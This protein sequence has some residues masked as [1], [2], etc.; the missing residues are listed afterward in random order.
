MKKEYFSNL[1][2]MLKSQL[3]EEEE[4]NYYRELTEQRSTLR[5][6]QIKQRIKSLT[7]LLQSLENKKETLFECE[8]PT[9]AEIY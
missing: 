1:V 8:T 6:Y 9:H 5:L 4:E 3:K 7:K 2:C